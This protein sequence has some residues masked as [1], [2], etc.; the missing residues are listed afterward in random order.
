MMLSSGPRYLGT[1][2]VEYIVHI[3]AIMKI[4]YHGHQPVRDSILKVTLK[5]LTHSL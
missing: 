2:R 1:L 4:D 3:T 5:R